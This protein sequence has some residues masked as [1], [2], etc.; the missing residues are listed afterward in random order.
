MIGSWLK[1][2]LIRGMNID[3]PRTTELRRQIIQQKRFLKKIYE[4]WYS[5][6]AKSI[7][8][9]VGPVLELGSG[10][11]FMKELIPGLITSEYFPCR[12]VNYVID[13]QALPFRDKS[14]RGIVMTNVLHHLPQPRRFFSES[15]RCLR[16]EG[17]IVMVE[18]WVTPWSTF[19][20]KNLHHE[21]FAPSSPTWEFTER[22]PLSGSNDAMPWIIFDRDRKRFESEF[23]ELRIEQIRLIMPFRYLLSGGV[24]M[25]RL[26]P[27]WTYAF[28]RMA[29]NAIQTWMDKVAMFA[30]IVVRRRS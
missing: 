9:G 17:V 16:E 11:G 10:G 1:H 12:G 19:V 22:G 28:W 3:D 29:E 13:A 6:I 15:R 21:P 7:P 20:Y 18:P 24:S 30:H 25:R 2:P 14:L 23:P 4:E 5:T 27:G 8:A 26:M